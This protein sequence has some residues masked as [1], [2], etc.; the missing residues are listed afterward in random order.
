MKVLA[1]ETATPASSVALGEDRVVVAS[2]ARVDRRGHG[3]FI[4]S[5]VDFC[6]DQAGW[7]PGDLDAIAIDVGPGLYTGIR[8]GLATAQGMAAA[9]GIP[10]VPVTSL[11]A[12][13]LR[14]ATGHRHVYAVVDVRRG[15]LAVASYRP[16]P[17]G[18][19]K[20]GPPEVMSPDHFRAMLES[21]P[22]EVLIVGDVADL[23]GSTVRG[24]HRVK[25]GRPRYP[26]AAALLD[27]AAGPLEKD[28]FPLPEDVRPLYLREPDVTI[29]WKQF[30]QEGPWD[31]TAST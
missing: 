16:V 22:D 5:A 1:I 19:V 7:N 13:A 15:E 9:L 29:S 17:G 31:D 8:V 18:V 23:P 24:L 20:D 26:E 4:V 28:D 6:F 30:R 11:D 2:A 10:I 12:V 3:S 27:L 25:S 14:A 21:D